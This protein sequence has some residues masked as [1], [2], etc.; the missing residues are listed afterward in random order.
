MFIIEKSYYTRSVSIVKWILF[1]YFFFTGKRNTEIW[2]IE[3]NIINNFLPKVVRI[4]WKRNWTNVINVLREY[5]E[6]D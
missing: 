1:T 6:R 4:L 2:I 5:N 3:G